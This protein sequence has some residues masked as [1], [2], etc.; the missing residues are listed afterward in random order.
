MGLWRRLN[1]ICAAICKPQLNLK[2]KRKNS[3]ELT[4]VHS[5]KPKATKQAEPARSSGSTPNTCTRMPGS[6]HCRQRQLHILPVLHVCTTTC[7]GRT[8]ECMTCEYFVDWTSISVRKTGH[9]QQARVHDNATPPAVP[10]HHLITIKR[11]PIG[12][13]S[14]PVPCRAPALLVA[15]NINGGLGIRPCPVS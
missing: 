12:G 3:A 4:K 8:G 1:D 15:Q 7:K 9:Q 11:L 6:K 14:G 10:Q 13:Q 5:G 2:T